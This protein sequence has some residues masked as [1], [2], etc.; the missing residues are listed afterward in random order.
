MFV[1]LHACLSDLEVAWLTAAH[2]AE[3]QNKNSARQSHYSDPWSSKNMF[4][5][6]AITLKHFKMH[7]EAGADI[8][9]VFELLYH[10]FKKSSTMYDLHL[11][12]F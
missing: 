7:C 4:N 9:H 11:I 3:Q 10:A 1:C 8:E 6:L 5:M 2:R 12:V